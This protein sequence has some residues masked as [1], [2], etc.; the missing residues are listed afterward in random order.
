M[1]DAAAGELGQQ[2]GDIGGVGRGQARRGDLLVAGADAQGAHAGGT[3]GRAAAK[4]WRQKV[5]TEVL[6]LV[7]VTATQTSGWAPQKAAAARA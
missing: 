1:G 4:I 3:C 2:L 5:A 6:P 7:P